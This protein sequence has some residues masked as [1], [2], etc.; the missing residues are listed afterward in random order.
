[1]V[2]EK[3]DTIKQ[4][5]KDALNGVIDIIERT[6]NSVVSKLN[7]F[8]IS[9]PD[10]VPKYGGASLGFNIPYAHIPRLAKGGIVN[11]PGKGRIVTVGEAGAEAILPLQNNTEWMDVLVDKVAEAVSMNVMNKIYLDGKEIHSSSRKYGSRF[12]FATNGGVL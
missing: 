6:I 2:E 7:S 10:W 1:M 5:M 8:R 9:I 4:G 3:F 12:D 11:N